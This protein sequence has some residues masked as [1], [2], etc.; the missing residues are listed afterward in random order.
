MKSN[1]INNKSVYLSLL[2][3]QTWF[4]NKQEVWTLTWILKNVEEGVYIR[5]E[6]KFRFALKKD[7]FTLGFIKDEMK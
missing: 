5:P 7:L 4:I 1:K 3:K 6:M 2:S